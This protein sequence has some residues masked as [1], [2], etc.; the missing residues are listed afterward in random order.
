LPV[1]FIIF[2]SGHSAA[3]F[4]FAIVSSVGMRAIKAVVGGGGRVERMVQGLCLYCIGWIRFMKKLIIILAIVL[5]IVPLCGCMSSE[6]NA[7]PTM[8]AAP[9][10]ASTT[11]A[12]S[13]TQAPTTLAPTT[14]APTTQPPTK[15]PNIEIN[16]ATI[17]NIY[18]SADNYVDCPVNL[19]V[20]I[21]NVLGEDDGYYHV[22]AYAYGQEEYNVYIAAPVKYKGIMY[23]DN[24][25]NVQGVCR[26]SDT[27]ENVFGSEVYLML[28]RGSSV[29]NAEPHE[30][31]DPTLE[32]VV[33]NKSKT[34]YG[35]T[36]TLEK[37]QFASKET[38]VFLKIKNGRSGDISYYEFNTYAIIGSRQYDTTWGSY[39]V[40]YP[41][42]PSTIHPG[43]LSE[44]II[45][46]EKI[47]P[48]STNMISL[49]IEVGTGDYKIGDYGDI[50][51]KFDVNI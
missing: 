48:D 33:V 29:S 51:I 37:I 27:S 7:T 44:G 13:T 25:I 16:A 15:K 5:M 38:R 4:V 23:T 30:T 1:S 43:V 45:L 28:I 2:P 6:E 31:V 17:N 47:N 34:S 3:A 39:L 8:T 11:T 9:T 36:V 20:R 24:C 32:E 26:G 19:N 46:F 12:A 35:I 22:Q 21:F 10:N 42:I 41:E 18:Y 50:T 40:D 49:Y 14:L